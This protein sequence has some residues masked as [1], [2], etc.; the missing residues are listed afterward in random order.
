MNSQNH[1]ADFLITARQKAI[2][3]IL[4]DGGI[5]EG[6]EFPD[7]RRYDDAPPQ[8]MAMMV[9]FALSAAASEDDILDIMCWGDREL[10]P[11]LRPLA[12]SI[13]VIREI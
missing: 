13:M 7:G 3:K 8:G 2:L 12:R 4:A 6:G 9:D 11:G 1:P 5:T 10:Y